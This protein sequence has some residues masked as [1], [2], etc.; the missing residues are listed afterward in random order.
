MIAATPSTN[1]PV[2]WLW[3]RLPGWLCSRRLPCRLNGTAAALLSGCLLLPAQGHAA[4]PLHYRGLIE[5]D[6][7][8]S[9]AAMPRHSRYFV[10]FILE[11]SVQDT[12]HSFWENGFTNANGNKGISFTGRFPTPFR[13]LRFTPDPTG[14]ATVDLSGM[15]FAYKDIGTSSARSVDVNQ[16]PPP[17]LPPCDVNPCINEHITLSIATQDPADPVEVI[18]L[19]LYN[20]TFYDPEYAFK[21]YL[22]DVSQPGDSFTFED[23]FINGP[24]DLAAFRS[25]RNPNFVAYDDGVFFDG[26]NGTLASGRFLSLE[27]V[28]GTPAPLPLLGVGAALGW[29]RR[30]RHRIRAGRPQRL[31]PLDPPSR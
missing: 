29:T 10:E 19:N 8:S 14:P 31:S 17:L 15:S 24:Q 9:I 26:P 5:L 18:F 25:Y 16:P 11:G 21:Q 28:T 20:S 7:G 4:A 23:L 22:L 13:F 1:C 6:H 2:I 3:A 12:D 27:Y 30:L